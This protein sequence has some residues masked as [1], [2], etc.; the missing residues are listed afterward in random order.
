MDG[1]A[2]TETWLWLAS[3]LGYAAPQMPELMRAYPNPEQLVHDRH[4]VDLSM[5]LTQKQIAALR[6]T[7]PED[8]IARLE[9]CARQSVQIVCFDSD[10]YPVLLRFTS[11]PPAVLYY[12][13][14]IKV[15]NNRTVFGIV[16]TRRPSA[17]GIE[18]T[19]AIATPLAKAGI[20]LVSG[21]ATG[22]DAECHRAAIAAEAPT[23]ACIAF[24]HDICYPA[25]HRA[26]KQTIEQQ[27]LVIGEYPP[28]TAIRKEYFL[29]RNRLIAGVAHGLCVA[30]A[31]RQSGTM[32]TVS[33]ALEAGRDVFAVPGSIF[34][35]LCE[36]TNHLLREG[37][38]PVLC[39]QDILDWYHL[40]DAPAELQPTPIEDAPISAAAREVY[41]QLGCTPQPLEAVCEALS[42]APNIVMAAL[43]ELELAGLICQ[44]AG[45]QFV[46]K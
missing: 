35:P 40:E 14:D 38:A 42:L 23:I 16:G 10:D 13:G 8:F 30:E 20:A 3:A 24:G 34:S 26:L 7:E 31:R 36:G 33:A 44:Q 37:A 18:A 4:T 32:N 25:N 43:T 21:L 2:R 41:T 46:L 5:L 22:L 11:A 6:V 27:G 1:Q 19:R 9:D 17:Y 29:Q 28:G 15:I 45:R 12:R 39:A